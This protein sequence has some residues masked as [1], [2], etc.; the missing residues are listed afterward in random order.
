M[1]TRLRLACSHGSIHG[2][3]WSLSPGSLFLWCQPHI[4]KSVPALAPAPNSCTR[5]SSLHYPRSRQHVTSSMLTEIFTG[6]FPWRNIP[7]VLQLFSYLI[8]EQCGC[9]PI[10][11]LAFLLSVTQSLIGT[12][13]VHS[14]SIT[15]MVRCV[16]RG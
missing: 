8:G 6:L 9:D 13:V 12:Y 16:T 11:A 7:R 3:G 14:S 10:A 1:H 4:Q 5:M 15:R 2:R